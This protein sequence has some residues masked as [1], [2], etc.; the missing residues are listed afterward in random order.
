LAEAAKIDNFPDRLHYKFTAGFLF[1]ATAILSM[2]KMWGESIQCYSNKGDAARA[3]NQFCWVTGTY[4]TV[5]PQSDF[6]SDSGKCPV[7]VHYLEGYYKFSKSTEDSTKPKCRQ[8][9]NY[10]QWVPYIFVLSGVLFMLPNLL[11]RY[12][13]EG[14]IASIVRGI[15][16][17]A[18]VQV[19]SNS[20]FLKQREIV[21]NNVAKFVV[22]HNNTRSHVKYAFSFMMCQHLNILNVIL[23]FFLIQIFLN[24]K[25]TTLGYDWWMTSERKVLT[26][27]FPRMT[28]CEWWQYGSGGEKEKTN[29]LCLLATNRIT[30]IIFVFYWFWLI[31]L[32]FITIISFIYYCS[33]FLSRSV[34][35]RD[36]FLAIAIND[37]RE[38]QDAKN[39]DDLSYQDKVHR[40]LGTMPSTKFFFLYLVGQNVDYETLKALSNK[41]YELA[42]AEENP[43]CPSTPMKETIEMRSLP[44]VR[45]N[46]LQDEEGLPGYSTI[47]TREKTF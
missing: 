3:V 40:Y 22:R 20:E 18:M 46:S 12:L 34:R 38:F 37:T 24:W 8:I 31:I 15:R 26:D 25:F 7:D 9:H 1:L 35:W 4:T 5:V 36:R 27:V 17:E 14:K 30:E 6:D 19:E 42:Q 39:Q 45:A 43:W 29:F 10:Y 16:D 44:S 41:M 32:A 33:L 23:N 47:D 28:M 11:W 21:V 2:D 13:E